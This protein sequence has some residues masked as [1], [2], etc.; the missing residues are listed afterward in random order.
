MAG[1][2][3]DSARNAPDKP[4]PAVNPK[5]LQAS[6]TSH[7]KISEQTTRTS[8]QPQLRDV[9][10]R[11]SEHL[12]LMRIED[13]HA[14]YTQSQQTA[15]EVDLLGYH[16][17]DAIATIGCLHGLGLQHGDLPLP[18]IIMLGE[19]STGKSSVIEAISGIKTPQSDGTCTCC[20]LFITLESPDD[21][22]A[23]WTARV[24]L[25]R[26]FQCDDKTS[27]ERRFPSYIQLPRPTPLHF[28]STE[29]PDRLE[30]IISRAQLATISPL[31]EH[32]EFLKPSIDRLD[33]F[34]WTGFSPNVV[35]I[36][37]SH[38]GLPSLSIYDL[39]GIIGQSDTALEVQLVRDLVTDYI[40]DPEALILVTCSLANDIANSV[41]GGILTKPDQ[42][43]EGTSHAMFSDIFDHKRFALG[44]GYFVVRNLGQDQ[45]DAGFTHQDA[46][47]QEQHFFDNEEPWATKLRHHESRFGT[48]N[49]QNT[50]IREV[51]DRLKHYSEPPTHNAS[52]II[53]DLVLNFSQELRQEIQAEY[54][55]K[56]WS[57]KW[58]AL[59][60][61]FFD[62]LVS[63]KPTL[64]TLARKDYGI[65]ATSTSAVILNA[66]SGHSFNDSIVIDE[67]DEDDGAAE[68]DIQMLDMPE[69]PTKKCKVEETPAPSLF[70]R[71]SPLSQDAKEESP[72]FSDKKAKFQLDALAGHLV[73]N[74][75]S[76]IPGKIEPRVVNDMMIATPG[77]WQLPLNDLFT[78]L[79][80]QL[81]SQVKELFHK[82]FA[83]WEDESLNDE[84]EGPYIFHSDIFHQDKDA[85]LQTYRQARFK[86]RLNVYRK[87]RFQKTRKVMTPAEEAKMLKDPKMIALLNREPYNV[88]LDV[89]AEVTT[90]YMLAARRFHDSICMRIESK[91]FKQ[92]RTQLRD[93]LENR[94]GIH[95]EKEGFCT[96]IDLL[97]EQSAREQHRREL[98]AQEGCST[99][100]QA[101]PP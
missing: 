23:K 47:I 71:A 76:R 33:G 99:S 70:T 40:K 97:A 36:T 89:A 28:M 50:R 83:K 86:A 20:P 15:S 34:H 39:P 59:Q 43:P 45:L 90:Y 63:L 32:T 61:S 5:A 42:I 19:Q 101:D 64:T 7:Q 3:R 58:R 87:E 2:T 51:E 62:G 49:L 26:Y 81:T 77:H 80:H 52:R 78:R 66:H 91:F 14:Q 6:S 41:A 56:N 46:R 44:H 12:E 94:L 65:F 54:P 35:E 4:V 17:K 29:D 22:H 88:E 100:R 57:N 24:S 37:I 93:E 25:R 31:V 84:L 95:D 30:T 60:K 79:E 69:T 38:P 85:I 67:E 27:A 11:L 68:G 72:D 18:K 55:C 73:D 1:L 74:S 21:P 92:L 16:V 98:V 13:Q 10:S 82:H 9:V 75:K 53:F 96:A 48:V 8:E